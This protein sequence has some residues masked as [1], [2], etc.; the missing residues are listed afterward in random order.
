M[1]KTVLTIEN[2][3]EDVKFDVTR[4]TWGEKK[5]AFKMFGYKPFANQVKVH[6]SMARF[7]AVCA[8]ARFGKSIM[9]AAE[10]LADAMFPNRRWWIVGKTYDIGSKEFQYIWDFSVNNP[11]KQFRKYINSHIIRKANDPRTGRMFIEFDWN[12]WIRVKSSQDP[13]TLLGE[14]LDGIILAEGS[15]LEVVYWQRYLRQRLA[16]RQGQLFVPTTPAGFDDFLHPLFLQGQDKRS[17]YGKTPYSGSTESWQ[18]R[19]ID[20]PYYP[21][22][23]WD[24]A[25]QDLNTGVL[26]IAAFEEQFGGEFTAMTGRVYKLF[27]ESVHVVEPYEIPKGWGWVRALDVGFDHPTCCLWG[28]IDQTGAIVIA[29]E[30]FMEGADVLE[31]SENIKAITT[32]M[33]VKES[34]VMWTVIDSA[35]DQRTAGNP[36]SVRIQYMQAGLNTL[37]CD[38]DIAAGVSR[39]TE[40]MRYQAKDGIVID[41]PKLKIM[42][43]CTRLIKELQGYVWARN[44]KGERTDKPIKKKDDGPDAL[45]YMIM[46][47]PRAIRKDAEKRIKPN[48]F[49]SMYKEAILEKNNLVRIRSGIRV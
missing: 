14:E 3:E 38:K 24:Q 27:H 16:S 44:Q 6:K 32:D 11:D 21:Q 4:L 9:S 39:V 5:R 46:R 47:Q 28:A 41:Q 18:F 36:V 19:S 20:S 17:H 29:E 30:Y 8:G 33:G 12:S 23:E 35:A 26:D 1:P 40:Y 10:C 48:S 7:R 22:E 15:Q 49:D 2:E 31:H 37:T 43:N 34:D 42:A 25:L 13:A 45:R